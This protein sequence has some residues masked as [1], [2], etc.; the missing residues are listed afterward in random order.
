MENLSI[1]LAALLSTYGMPKIIAALYILARD[2][3]E[4]QLLESA[5]LSIIEKLDSEDN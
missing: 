4:R 2:F 5:M 3:S 1:A